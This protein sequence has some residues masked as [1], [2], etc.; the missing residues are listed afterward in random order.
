MTRRVHLL[1]HA[2][3]SWDD[4][5]LGD[6]DRPLAP[7]GIKASAR[8]AHWIQEN[9][10]RPELILCSSALR[11]TETLAKVEHALGSPRIVVADSFY[12]ASADA[13]KHRLSQL[14]PTLHDVLL[15]GHNP[16]LADVCQMLAQPSQEKERIAEKLPTG[17]FVTL[18]TRVDWADLGPG[19]ATIV[20]L[21]L[22][23]EL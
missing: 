11:A 7:R 1:R 12:A 19:C 15:I 9:D 2:K 13:L 21:V 17:A 18:E 23:R 4:A 8:L 16:G 6:H 14:S 10:I 5:T 3:S 20:H 22:P